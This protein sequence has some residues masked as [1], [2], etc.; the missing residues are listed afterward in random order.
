MN[1]YNID[2]KK[3]DLTNFIKYHPGGDDIKQFSFNKTKMD[4]NNHYIMIHQRKFP[5]ESMKSYLIED[6]NKE[7]LEISC[8]GKDLYEAIKNKGI[9]NKLNIMYYTKSFGITSLMILFNTYFILSGSLVYAI[10]CSLF[11][12]LFMFNVGHDL[13]HGVVTNKFYYYIMKNIV[14]IY[15]GYDYN[16][17]INEHI[18]RHH[19]YTNN[20]I[21]D[22]NIQHTPVLSLHPNANMNWCNKFQSYY[23]FIIL[24]VYGLRIP[25]EKFLF[26]FKFILYKIIFFSRLILLPLIF[27][28]NINTILGIIL[29]LC[30]Q[31]FILGSIFIISHNFD[32][33]KK[34][35]SSDC[36]YKYQ[37]ENSSSYGG[38]LACYLTGGLNYQ[39]EH[40][41]FPRISYIYYPEI[42]P[43]VMELCKKHNVNYT[44]FP[45]Y[46]E[47]VKST[48]NHLYKLTNTNSS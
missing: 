9:Y 32:G 48:L 25:F 26:D 13:S 10:L 1:V 18:V 19:N 5:H 37:V 15:T 23:L 30:T 16:I 47:N 2:G 24:L 20:V 11:I 33:A 46:Y 35:I 12:C 36:W 7:T 31:G 44:Y 29:L 43:I 45:T 27:N 28:Y 38:K 21:I 39:I 40:H 8:F 3:Y 4:I 34:E 6:S 14:N 42:Q 41:L 22:E 17:W